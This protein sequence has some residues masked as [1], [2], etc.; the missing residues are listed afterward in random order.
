VAAAIG[1]ACSSTSAS[2]AYH[3]GSN[4]LTVA[5]FRFVVPTIALIIWLRAS[6]TSLLLSARDG[7]IAL[8]LGVIT[9]LYTL[10]WL[11]S[12]HEIPL[13]V[14]VLVFYLFPLLAAVILVVCGWEKFSW[15]SA[16]AILIAFGGLALAL[17]PRGHD[18][19]FEGLL[20]AFGGALGL[21]LVITI[22]SRVFRSGDARPLTLYMAGFAAI[23]LLALCAVRGQFV[24]PVTTLGWIGFVGAAVS[25]GFAMIAFYIAMSMVGPVRASLLSYTEPVIS[26]GLGVVV[27]GEPLSAI[28]VAGIAL[29]VVALVG[30]T[31][32]RSRG[33]AA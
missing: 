27:L 19:N 3:G 9:A 5:A 22:S 16:V 23:L 17:D 21:A 29:V 33:A 31:L 8:A 4:P 15:Q 24:F 10:S 1:Y 2:L 18:L 28:Q 26:A 14:A 6:R 32:V 30:A 13:A 11:S 12:L 20:L 25:Y 7:W